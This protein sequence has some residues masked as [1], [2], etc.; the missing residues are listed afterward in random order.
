MTL[1]PIAERLAGE[2]SLSVFYDLS[3]S[4]MGFEHPTLRLRGQRF[5]KLLHRIFFVFLFF[6]LF[7]CLFLLLLRTKD[8]YFLIFLF[9]QWTSEYSELIT[10][11]VRQ[12]FA[13]HIFDF[14]ISYL[15]TYLLTYL[16]ILFISAAIVSLYKGLFFASL[17]IYNM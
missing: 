12:I 8:D 3:L 15:L 17:A 10:F 16:L 2:L 13:R 14:L 7:V 5:N 1:T 4:R 11:R 6:V 9:K